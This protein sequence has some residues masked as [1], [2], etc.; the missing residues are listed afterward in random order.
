MFGV[1]IVTHGEMANG[2][3]DAVTMILG[4]PEGK[5]SHMLELVGLKEGESPETLADEVNDKIQR[6]ILGGAT[7][8]IVLTD[9]FGSSTANAGVNSM[10]H[11][12]SNDKE[13]QKNDIAVVSGVNLPML[14]EVIPGSKTCQTIDELTN[15]AVDSGKRNIIS[16][17]D[18]I[19][20][21]KKKT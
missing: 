3:M 12:K 5:D 19:I 10:L 9:L 8:V 4:E 16:A 1:L 14:L 21:R 18:E 6:M 13:T 7:G 17:A 15:L 20:K 11:R 2:L